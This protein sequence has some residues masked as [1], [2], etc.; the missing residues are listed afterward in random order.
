ML[1]EKFRAEH[2]RIE[3]G[4]VASEA[5]AA[6]AEKFL[7]QLIS[8]RPEVLQHFLQKDALYPALLAQCEKVV[9][10]P[11]TT[12]IRIFES[13]MRVQ[14]AAVRRFFEGLES[15]TPAQRASSFRTVAIVI[16]QRFG[17]EES[18]VFPI[19]VRTFKNEKAA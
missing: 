8:M 6:D 9:D 2:A 1:V 18:A 10:A 15:A 19:Y 14:S 11:G 4:L 16:R 3:K 7:A 12:L 13:N 17:T 5:V